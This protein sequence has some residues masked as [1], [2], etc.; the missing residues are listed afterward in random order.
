MS[1][2][3]RDVGRLMR[4]FHDTIEALG[5]GA[6]RANGTPSPSSTKPLAGP[7]CFVFRAK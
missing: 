5:D 7:S 3:T 1:P 6:E 4:L 2:A